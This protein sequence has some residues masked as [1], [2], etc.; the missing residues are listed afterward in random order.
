METLCGGKQQRRSRQYF[1]CREEEGVPSPCRVCVDMA[2]QWPAYSTTKADGGERERRGCD[3]I[4]QGG[5][6][7]VRHFYKKEQTG[8]GHQHSLRCEMLNKTT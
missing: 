3:R 2:Q 5:L 1:E 7:R 6:E 4:G 8:I